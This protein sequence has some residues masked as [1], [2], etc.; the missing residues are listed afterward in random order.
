MS[1]EAMAGGD[2]L[3]KLTKVLGIAHNNGAGPIT[4]LTIERGGDGRAMYRARSIN[5]VVHSGAFAGRFDAELLRVIGL[6]SIAEVRTWRLTIQTNQV[7]M[8][9]CSAYFQRDNAK[10]L[11]EYLST[12]VTS[13]SKRR[14]REPCAT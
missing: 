7:V 13:L 3:D 2:I 14:W 8:V 5:G 12:H 9:E 1:T 4:T 11:V 6:S 10:G